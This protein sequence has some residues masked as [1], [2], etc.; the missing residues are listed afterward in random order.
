MKPFLAPSSR[1]ARHGRTGYMAWAAFCVLMLLL[2]SCVP[3]SPAALVPHENPAS[4]P[5]RFSPGDL[6]VHVAGALQQL[7]LREY[8]SAEELLSQVDADEAHIP[9]ALR[10]ICVRYVDLCDELARTLDGLDGSLS[11]AERLLETNE[12]APARAQLEE[13]RRL[14]GLAEEQL[15]SLESATAEA[16]ALVGRYGTGTARAAVI[17]AQARL[18]SAI[19]RLRELT[20]E[21]LR[22]LDAD[23]VQLEHRIA[24]DSPVLTCRPGTDAV[25]VGEQV[26]VSGVL[27]SPGG[28]LAA[29]TVQVLVEG[30]AAY[31]AVT[32]AAG[33]YA[34]Q[35]SAP[36]RYVPRMT[37]QARFSPA[38]SDLASLLSAASAPVEVTVRYYETSI[39]ASLPDELQPGVSTTLLGRLRSIGAVGQRPVEVLLAGEVVGDTLTFDDGTFVCGVRVPAS[40]PE[41]ETQ[42]SVHVQPVDEMRTGPADESAEVLVSRV[43]PSLSLGFPGIVLMPSVRPLDQLLGQRGVTDEGLPVR[44]VLDSPLPLTA[45]AL[46]ARIGD[47]AVRLSGRAGEVWVT[48]PL[49]RS[50]WTVGIQTARLDVVPA[51]PWHRPVTREARF[52]VVNLILVVL[53]LVVLCWI[54]VMMAYVRR[55]QV[56]AVVYVPAEAP[57]PAASSLEPVAARRFP[58]SSHRH[59]V[60]GLYLAAARRVEAL[61]GLAFGRTVT[62]REF[63]SSCGGLIGRAGTF[64]ARLTSLA[65]EALYSRREVGAGDVARSRELADLIEGDIVRGPTGPQGDKP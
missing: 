31:E 42:L 35:V 26:S 58:S 14:V 41:G 11:A 32:D 36:Y 29:R 48:F 15:S 51:E 37:L 27:S 49:R 18:E 20:A 4:A 53:A 65:E 50:V 10:H 62:L 44:L 39:E 21:Y 7:A 8:G 52:L 38:G 9:E 30:V 25:W 46:V 28:P 22:R 47:E 13:A 33:A 2:P 24:L 56:Q 12:I 40:A 54:V 17:E 19:V 59:A 60:V 63:L 34:L 16:I 43:A 1:P 6:F 57:T 5:S 23:V 64:F 3:S 55:G 61:T 45:P